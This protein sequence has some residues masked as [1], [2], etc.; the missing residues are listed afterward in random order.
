[1]RQLVLAI[2]LIFSA[3]TFSEIEY[4]GVSKIS[5]YISYNQYGEGDVVFRVENPMPKCHGYWIAKTDP[6]FE[7]NLSSILAAYHSKIKIKVS[8]HDDQKWP[9]SS[10]FW[11]KLYSIEYVQ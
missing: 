9:G 5:N 11:C 6:G 7:A 4:G 2:G 1:M 8:G 10:N 3:D